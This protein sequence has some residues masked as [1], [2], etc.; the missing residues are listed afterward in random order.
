MKISTL[1]CLLAAMALFMAQSAAMAQQV[2]VPCVPTGNGTNTNGCQPVTAEN[3]LPIS[4]TFSATSTPTNASGAYSSAT[5]GTSSAQVLAA[6]T[7]KTLLDIVNESTTATIACALGAT[8]VIN[9]A[10]SIT[11]PPGWHRSWEGSFVPSDAVNCIAS[12]ASTPISIGA[13]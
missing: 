1:R 8:A 13:K 11:I 6:S 12:G 2:V 3:P 9:G 10:G 5:V 4:G 7:A